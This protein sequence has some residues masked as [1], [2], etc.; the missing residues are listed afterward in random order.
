MKCFSKCIKLQNKKSPPKYVCL[1]YIKFSDPLL[2]THYGFYLTLALK[3]RCSFCSEL[4]GA[5]WL[6]GRVIDSRLKGRGFEPHR[7]H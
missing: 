6:S 2:E 5:Q 4:K 7:R 3:S 1:P